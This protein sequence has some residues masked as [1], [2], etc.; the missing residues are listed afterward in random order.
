[1]RHII[2]IAFF[3]LFT[4]TFAQQKEITFVNKSFS[5]SSIRNLEVQTSGGSI[6]VEGSSSQEASVEVILSHNGNQS[7]PNK[8]LKA[9]F[10]EEYDLEL[11]V[12]NSILIAK[13]VRKNN[14]G[15]NPLS[16]SFRVSVPTKTDIDLKTAGG[17][18]SLSSLDGKLSFTTSGGSLSINNVKGS[19]SGNT[20]GGSISASNAA[21]H[22]NLVTSGGSIQLNGLEGEV[23]AQTSGGSISA[24]FEK[25]TGPIDLS[26]SGGSVKIIVPKD[27]YELNLKGTSVNKPSGNFVGASKRNSVI[28]KVNG[29]GHTIVASTSGGTIN[30]SWK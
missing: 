22:I 20:S 17:S 13:A 3:L 26:T 18:I 16:V 4:Y 11:E 19:I 14:R 24:S 25:V 1:M 23:I 30:L 10:D 5:A 8:N 29:G 15:N 21:G 2:T 28:G 7:R 12:K 9:I 6:R 27:G